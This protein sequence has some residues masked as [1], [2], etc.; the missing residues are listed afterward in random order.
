MEF[1]LAGLEEL[2]QATG[3]KAT[4]SVEDRANICGC[5]LAL[6]VAVA[7]APVAAVGGDLLWVCGP[8]LGAVRSG[9][10]AVSVFVRSG[11]VRFCGPVR[12]ILN[13]LA[14]LADVLQPAFPRGVLIEFGIWLIGLTLRTRFHRYALIKWSS[15]EVCGRR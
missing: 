6:C 12:G 1:L 14:R 8:I 15:W 5:V 7:G 9:L 10:L 2:A 13:D 4:L 3:A 11:L